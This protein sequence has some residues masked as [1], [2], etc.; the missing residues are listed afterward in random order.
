MLRSQWRRR[1]GGILTRFPL[2]RKMIVITVHGFVSHACA[3]PAGLLQNK[4]GVQ[5]GSSDEPH[6]APVLSICSR[7]GSA[8]G[9]KFGIA[10]ALRDIAQA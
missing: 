10:M 3:L 1:S 6:Q 2:I 8:E 7:A 5:D 4:P 9:P